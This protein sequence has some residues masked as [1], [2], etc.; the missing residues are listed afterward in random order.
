VPAK[1]DNVLLETIPQNFWR[2][3]V[4]ALDPAV[5]QRIMDL[6]AAQ[7]PLSAAAPPPAEVIISASDSLIMPPA[8]VPGPGSG[9]R[10]S[11]RKSKQAKVVGDWAEGIALRYIQEQMAG[12]ADCVHRA[13]VGETP[14]WDIDFRDADGVLQRVE[15]KGTVAGDRRLACA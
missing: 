1:I 14:G 13:A 3:G 15:V 11:F 7:P 10:S 8:P 2:D 5:Y 4:R 6:A 12:C 9:I